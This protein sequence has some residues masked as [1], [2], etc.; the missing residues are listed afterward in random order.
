MSKNLTFLA[1]FEE[2]YPD[3]QDLA[4]YKKIAKE[5]KNDRSREYQ[6]RMAEVYKKSK[7]SQ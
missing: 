7:E 1:Y 4:E 2:K 3:S 5:R 6:R